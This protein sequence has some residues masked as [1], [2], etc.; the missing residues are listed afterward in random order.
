MA[1]FHLFMIW[2]ATDLLHCSKFEVDMIFFH[3]KIVSQ[4]HAPYVQNGGLPLIFHQKAIFLLLPFEQ[5]PTFNIAVAIA[6]NSK[7]NLFRSYTVY[8]VDKI[9]RHRMTDALKKH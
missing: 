6:K 3:R 7:E 9:S 2:G 8:S 1:D 4:M 5:V